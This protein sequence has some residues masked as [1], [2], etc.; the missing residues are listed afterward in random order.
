MYF[1]DKCWRNANDSKEDLLLHIPPKRNKEM[2]S[3]KEITQQRSTEGDI[4]KSEGLRIIFDLDT[5]ALRPQN[6]N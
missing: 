4:F 2:A 1:L 6:T 3:Y 5:Y